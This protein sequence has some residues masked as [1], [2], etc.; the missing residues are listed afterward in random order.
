MAAEEIHKGDVGTIIEITV[1]DDSVAI[2]V[3]GVSLKQF[4][5]QKPDGSVTTKTAA[6]KT[7]GTDGILTYTTIVDDLDIPGAWDVQAYIEWSAGW[8]GH[9]DI[10]TFTVYDNVE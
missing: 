7:D 9:S 2:D 10:S 3:S 8:K 5:F 1:K 4:K 6:F